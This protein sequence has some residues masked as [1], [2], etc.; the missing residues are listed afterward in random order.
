MSTRGLRRLI[1]GSGAL[2]ALPAAGV[3]AIVIDGQNIP[4]D[5]GASALVASQLWQTGFGNDTDGGQF[6]GGSELDQM[7]IK[8]DGTYLYLGITGNLENNGNCI[9]IFIDKNGG[10]VTNG[11]NPMY[12]Q[13]FG[14]PI[15]NLPRNLTGIP[16]GQGFN[17]EVFD[18]GF[19]PTNAIVINGGSPV[20]SQIR[21][22]YAVNWVS[23][24]DANGADPLAHTNQVAGIMTAGNPT[25]SGPSGTLGTFL[26]TG[27]P[28]ILAA[29]D[30]SNDFGVDGAFPSNAWTTNPNTATKGF[31][32]AIP[33]SLLGATPGSQICLMAIVSGDSGYKSNQILPAPDVAAPFNNLGSVA[34]FSDFNNLAGNQ[35][36]CYT[37]AAAGCP[38]GNQCDNGDLNGDCQVNL[39]DLA[40]LLANFGTGSGATR[41]QGDLNGDGAVN[42]TDL[43]TMLAVFGANCN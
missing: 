16:F 15:A 39:T 35:Y 31:E 3:A 12:T 1:L 30:N 33:L 4:T 21:T 9:I 25:A 22:Y 41:A 29:A 6:G 7:F 37:I 26:S 14:Q 10:A 40:T 5:F 24:A 28:G 13:A 32:F 38:G 17:G 34:D 43:A 42:L 8:N 20:G 23:F 27:N 2:L 18:A 36:L 11:A 19:S